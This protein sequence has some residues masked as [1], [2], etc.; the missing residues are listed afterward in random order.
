MAWYTNIYNWSQKNLGG[1]LA[2][3]AG[4]GIAWGVYELRTGGYDKGFRE[5]KQAASNEFKQYPIIDSLELMNDINGD[6]LPDLAIKR[7]DEACE[8]A[9]MMPDGRTFKT[10]SGM[11][12]RDQEWNQKATDYFMQKNKS[13]TPQAPKPAYFPDCRPK[14]TQPKPVPSESIPPIQPT[15]Q[16]APSGPALIRPNSY[17]PQTTSN[18]TYSNSGLE[19]IASTDSQPDSNGLV[20]VQMQR[21]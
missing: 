20:P 3:A 11:R 15:P 14:P 9:V 6:N 7:L 12:R 10:F 17:N 4:I 1:A 13:E 16:S 18:S 5:G 2:A 21:Q 19:A 8:T